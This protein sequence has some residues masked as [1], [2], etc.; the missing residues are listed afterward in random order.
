MNVTK[1]PECYILPRWSKN[2]K[3]RHSNDLGKFCSPNGSEF[4]DEMLFVN[5]AMRM[6]L[7]LS[8]N[9][10]HSKECI[11]VFFERLGAFKNEI[12]TLC[13]GVQS[14]VCPFPEADVV[15]CSQQ[16]AST[17]Q[18]SNHLTGSPS[19]SRIYDPNHGW[20]PASF[21]DTHPSLSQHSVN[22]NLDEPIDVTS[23]FHL[24]WVSAHELD[25]YSNGIGPSQ[26]IV[27]VKMNYD[28]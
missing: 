27:A 23:I 24:R 26:D 20:I 25:F 28:R 18:Q 15:Q 5:Y 4:L 16:A 2:A 21:L 11:N 1:L 14:N 22:Y 8:H 13:G 7:E 19:I 12:T 9:A 10:K 17:G 6:T 3:Q